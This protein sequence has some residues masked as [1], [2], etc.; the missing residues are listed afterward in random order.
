MRV[1]SFTSMLA[2]RKRNPAAGPAAARKWRNRFPGK[3]NAISGRKRASRSQR[4]PTWGDKEKI[5]AMYAQARVMTEMLG[6]PWRVD[7][8][9]PLRGKLVSGLH[10]H[11]NLR[12]LPGVENMQKRNTF[13]VE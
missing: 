3:V 12:I 13:S 2:F 7:H 4:T 5:D 11:A 8:E 6:E 9:I 10:V 1:K